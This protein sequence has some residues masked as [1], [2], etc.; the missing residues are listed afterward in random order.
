M[1]PAGH[2]FFGKFF[3]SGKRVLMVWRQ[4]YVNCGYLSACA[5]VS[6][7]GDPM[8]MRNPLVASV[9]SEE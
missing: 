5:R 8:I 1:I 2:G 3:V 9:V 7:A 6:A 4:V